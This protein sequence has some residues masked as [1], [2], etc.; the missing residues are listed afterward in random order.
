MPVGQPKT[1]GSW[2]RD[3]TECG[4]LEKGM[5]NHFSILALRTPWTVWKAYLSLC[6]TLDLEQWAGAQNAAGAMARLIG[7]FPL[8]LGFWIKT[9]A[10]TPRDPCLCLAP[11]LSKG[12]SLPTGMRCGSEQGAPYRCRCLPP[13]CWL[14]W[15]LPSLLLLTPSL[16]YSTAVLAWSPPTFVLSKTSA[17]WKWAVLGIPT[18]RSW[19]QTTQGWAQLLVSVLQHLRQQLSYPQG[20]LHGSPTPAWDTMKGMNSPSEL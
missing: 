7:F 20:L 16:G 11:A 19:V 8:I 10:R 1:G 4:P 13:P 3:L 12:P 9:L 2:W 6:L 15:G 17:W 14:E 5:A 18:K